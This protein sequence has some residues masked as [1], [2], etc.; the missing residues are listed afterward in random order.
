MDL[1]VGCR[2]PDFQLVTH[3]LGDFPIPLYLLIHHG[4]VSELLTLDV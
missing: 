2:Q 3:R 4:T 1:M